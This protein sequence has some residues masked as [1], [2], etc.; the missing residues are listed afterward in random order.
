[1]FFQYTLSDVFL[2]E[3]T[4]GKPVT[5]EERVA[6]TIWKLA[7]TTVPNIIKYVWSWTINSQ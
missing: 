1:M 6:V 4:F 5:V 7:Q 2:Q 3:T